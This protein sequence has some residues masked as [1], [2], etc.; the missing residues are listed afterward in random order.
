L[1]A[2]QPREMRE[3]LPA[4]F[5]RIVAGYRR[6]DAFELPVSAKL[7]SASKPAATVI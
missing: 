5:D 6:V 3:R 2:R 7:A 4:A 1:I